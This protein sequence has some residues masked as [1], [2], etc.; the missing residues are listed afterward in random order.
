MLQHFLPE[1]FT[2][3]PSQRFSVL[4]FLVPFWQTRTSSSLSYTL[5]QAESLDSVYLLILNHLHFLVC[6]LSGQ[7]LSLHFFPFQFL[8][9]LVSTLE[10]V[11]FLPTHPT[12]GKIIH[13]KHISVFAPLSGYMLFSEELWRQARNKAKVTKCVGRVDNCIRDL[14]GTGRKIPLNPKFSQ[15]EGK[16]QLTQNILTYLDIPNCQWTS[17]DRK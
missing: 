15:M 6:P 12:N 1:G 7:L 3:G 9:T 17:I 5:F 4:F 8:F 2:S 16:A 11:H 14:S 13:S 10:F